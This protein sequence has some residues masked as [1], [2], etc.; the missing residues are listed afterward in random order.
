[1]SRPRLLLHTCCGP[2]A[3]VC[4]ERLQPAHAVTLL[5]YNPNLYP[6]Q[7]HERR[8]IAARRVAEHFGVGMIEIPPEPGAWREAI[9]VIQ[10]WESQDEGGPRCNLCMALRITHTALE[11]SQRGFDRFSTS[12]LV[13]PHKNADFISQTMASAAED[14]PPAQAVVVS[15]RERGGFARSVELSKQLGLYRQNYCG[16]QCSQKAT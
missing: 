12:L 1:M 9:S 7:E 4:V 15:F 14:N 5:W 10:G 6:P 11:A 13:S 2:C 8:L 16:C 3:A